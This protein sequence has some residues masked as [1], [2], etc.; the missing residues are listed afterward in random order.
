MSDE[1]YSRWLDQLW[2]GDLGSLEG[3]AAR[4]VTPTFVGNWP[5]NP[6]LV[7]GPDALAAVVRQGRT[8]FDDDLTFT[9]EIGPVAQG[10][11][12]T[13]RWVAR[14]HYRGKPTEFH[15][16]DILRHDGERFTE[17][18]VLSESPPGLDD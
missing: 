2:S 13:A 8:M 4:V 17:Y 10:G 5:N 9:T 11:L 16:H 6:G 1:L 15:G 7:H 12:I 18:W 14:G 3:I